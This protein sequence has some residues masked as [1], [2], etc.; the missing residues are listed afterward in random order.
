MFKFS[1]Q[2]AEVE[3]IDF[4]FTD[5]LASKP[6]AVYQ[7]YTAEVEPGLTLVASGYTNGVVK[8]IVGGGVHG[9]R[10]K[11]TVRLSLDIGLVREAEAMIVVKEE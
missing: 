7:S 11:V 2:P 4:D 8:V 6:G 5:W 1:K 3:D 9:S 10:Y